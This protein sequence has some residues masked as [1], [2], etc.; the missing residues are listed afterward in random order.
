MYVIDRKG[1][2]LFKEGPGGPDS[3]GAEDRN[4]EGLVEALEA[5]GHDAAL[6]RPQRLVP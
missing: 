6:R 5:G 1:V 4:P 2:S 3:K